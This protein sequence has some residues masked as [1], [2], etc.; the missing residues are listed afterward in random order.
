MFAK[1]RTD[2][3]DAILEKLLKASDEPTVMKSSTESCLPS[4]LKL[5][6]DNEAPRAATPK[7]DIVELKR[8]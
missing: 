2:K 4:R 5:R 7:T 8:A 6:R 3:V 1:P